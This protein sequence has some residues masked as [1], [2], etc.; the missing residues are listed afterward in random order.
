MGV[1]SNKINIMELMKSGGGGDPTL[2]GRVSALET[3]TAGLIEANAKIMTSVAA[4]DLETVALAEG[5]QN[6]MTSV[7][8]G[9]VPMQTGNNICFG[10]DGNGNYGYYKVGADT[11]TPFLTGGGGGGAYDYITNTPPSDTNELSFSV[12]SQPKYLSIIAQTNQGYA[13]M[14]MYIFARPTSAGST[15]TTIVGA[16]LNTNSDYSYMSNINWSGTYDSVN[17]TYTIKYT[18]SDGYH[19]KGTLTH[20]ILA[21]YE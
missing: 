10:V 15:T 12:A 8:S 18:G 2:P 20:R 4:L 5:L 11:V 19:F 13:N 6:V 1:V 14:I 21:C 3:E 16:A 17:N 9:R 7:S